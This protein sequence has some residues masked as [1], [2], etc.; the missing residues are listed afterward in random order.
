VFLEPS[1]LDPAKRLSESFATRTDIHGQYSFIGLAPANYRLLASFDYSTVDS[2]T[3]S[4]AGAKPIRVES[5]SDAQQDLDL[6]VG[7]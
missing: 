4:Y 7:P 2:A 6:Y 5:G 1:D 3:M